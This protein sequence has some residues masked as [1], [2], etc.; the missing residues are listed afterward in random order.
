M[1][2]RRPIA[3]SIVLLIALAAPA[4]AVIGFCA[5]MPCCSHARHARITTEGT[6]CCTTINCYEAPS[7]ELTTRSSI[8]VAAVPV[9]IVMP[10]FVGAHL[11]PLVVTRFDDTSP[12][13]TV[14]ERLS[15]LAI[16]LI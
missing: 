9:A 5:K 10:V 12:P 6:D 13:R 4:T 8:K 2:T 3:L 14:Q 16:L 1:L 7:Q 11:R 15:V